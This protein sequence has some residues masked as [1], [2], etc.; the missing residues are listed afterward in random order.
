MPLL[1]PLT[2]FLVVSMRSKSS[3]GM[4]RVQQGPAPPKGPAWSREKSRSCWRED[5]TLTLASDLLCR[6]GLPHV[7]A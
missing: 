3:L 4:G 5:E 1:A 6:S 2:L 7:K